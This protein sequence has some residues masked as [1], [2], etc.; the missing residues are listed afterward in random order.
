MEPDILQTWRL[1]E[2]AHVAVTT[3]TIAGWTP[4]Q[5]MDARTWALLEI[6][7]QQHDEPGVV[8]PAFLL[9]PDVRERIVEEVRPDVVAMW[10]DP[11][12]QLGLR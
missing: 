3:A 2:K 5:R 8:W 9:E 4:H 6:D 11:L 10:T 7:A 12:E 1:L